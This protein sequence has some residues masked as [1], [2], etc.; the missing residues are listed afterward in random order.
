MNFSLSTFLQ[1]KPPSVHSFSLRSELS[2]GIRNDSSPTKTTWGE[3]ISF[4]PFR[5]ES[6][7]LLSRFSGFLEVDFVLVRLSEGKIATSFL[8]QTFPNFEPISNNNLNQEL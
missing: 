4:G 1:G 7:L 2:K 6:R 5:S 3:V 8:A